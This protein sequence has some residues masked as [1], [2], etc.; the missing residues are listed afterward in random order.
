MKSLV[1]IPLFVLIPLLA[2][3]QVG[4]GAQDTLQIEPYHI[5]NPNTHFDTLYIQGYSVQ[6]LVDSTGIAVFLYDPEK[7]FWRFN[8]SLSTGLID[9]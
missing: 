4:I 1:L 6:H 2:F 8:T 5:A 3:S 9:N 7:G